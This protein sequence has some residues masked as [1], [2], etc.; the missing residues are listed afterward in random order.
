MIIV[1]MLA[2]A[3]DRAKDRTAEELIERAIA[4]SGREAKVAIDRKEG[5]ITVDLGGP[6]VPRGWP[7]DV[8]VYPNGRRLRIVEESPRS[9]SL[10]LTTADSPAALADFYR[11][12]LPASGWR[13]K[14]SDSA[15]EKILARKD[16]RTIVVQF[17]AR[18]KGKGS[19]A[20]IE[21]REGA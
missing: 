16:N 19:R 1:A 17:S 9:Q 13:L 4:E 15:K 10:T 7:Q 18:G 21:L 3:C 2:V 14:D 5:S 20:G 11:K 6:V 8:P 12:Q